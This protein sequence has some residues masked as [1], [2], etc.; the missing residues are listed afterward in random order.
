[1]T[2]LSDVD[3]SIAAPDDDSRGEIIGIGRSFASAILGLRLV[4][5]STYGVR[6]CFLE[7]SS[8]TQ[9]AAGTFTE[10][11]TQLRKVTPE[12]QA[13]LDAMLDAARRDVIEDGMY[14][15]INERLPDLIARDFSAVIPAI[16]SVIEA[17]R[18]A[19]VIAAE[20]L[21][22]LG[23]LRDSASHTNRLWV[24]ERAL[25]LSSSFVRDGAG[26]GLAT[27]ADAR[28]LPYLRRAIENE[29]DSQTKADL[30]LVVDELN[31]LMTNGVPIASR[32]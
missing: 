2:R 14:N 6:Q 5:A 4:V 32:L 16:M 10:S 29:P 21:K 22:E 24:L 30:Q 20:V 12:I 3:T 17:G 25:G 13:K 23:R 8:A 11:S 15:A 7:Q 26:L 18:T 1:M 9:I 19:P 27:L 28:A 31:E